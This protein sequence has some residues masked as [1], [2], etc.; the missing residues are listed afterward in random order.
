MRVL[1]NTGLKYSTATK[2]VV[3]IYSKDLW[4]LILRF[5]GVSPNLGYSITKIP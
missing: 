1:G 5:D 3:N 2:V 4:G